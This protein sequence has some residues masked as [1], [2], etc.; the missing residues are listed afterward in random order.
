MEGRAIGAILHKL[1]FFKNVSYGHGWSWILLLQ[2]GP[3]LV[4][5]DI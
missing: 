5:N 4:S 1:F 2:N 3:T